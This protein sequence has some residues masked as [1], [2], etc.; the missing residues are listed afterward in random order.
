MNVDD[1]YLAKTSHVVTFP[2]KSHTLLCLGK[3]LGFP[4]YEVYVKNERS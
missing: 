4:R 3:K 2:F 1:C